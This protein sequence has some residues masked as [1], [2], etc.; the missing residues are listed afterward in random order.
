MRWML[1]IALG[2]AYFLFSAAG[3]I[4]IS[5]LLHPPGA[6]RPTGLELTALAL[7][8]SGLLSLIVWVGSRLNRRGK[9]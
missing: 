1:V 9:L 2:L 8:L 5:R 6:H 4:V 3:G 7:W